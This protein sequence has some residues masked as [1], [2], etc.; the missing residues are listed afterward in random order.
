MDKVVECQYEPEASEARASG[1]SEND[2][3]LKPR[4]KGQA[5]FIAQLDHSLAL[6]RFG[7]VFRLAW[8]ATGEQRLSGSRDLM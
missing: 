2:S 8:H 6:L 7:L 4:G 1:L 3:T 5:L